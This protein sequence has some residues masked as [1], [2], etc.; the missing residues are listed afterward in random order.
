MSK[1]IKRLLGATALVVS[2]LFSVAHAAAVTIDFEPT[3]LVNLYFPGDSFVQNGF[4]LTADYDAGLVDVASALGTA[5]PS[6]NATQ[7]FAGLNNG[8]L[9]LERDGGG[10]FNLDGFSAAFV[11][12]IP[13]A[14]GQT[15]FVALATYADDSVDGLAWLFGRTFGLYDHPADFAFF[16]EVKRVDFFACTYDGV[17]ICA[18]DPKNNGQFAIDDIRLTTVPEPSTLA[19]LPLILLGLALRSRRSVR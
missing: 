5:A 11:P 3:E 6:G 10:L 17:N 14:T 9:I 8:G 2:T 7:F 16:Q 1:A 13:A 18:A 19:L 12:L 15:V 4:K